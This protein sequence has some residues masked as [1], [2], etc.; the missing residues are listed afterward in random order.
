MTAVRTTASRRRRASPLGADFAGAGRRSLLRG[1]GPG[2]CGGTH[3]FRGPRDGTGGPFRGGKALAA[4][5]GARRHQRPSGPR[6]HRRDR[7]DHRG[8]RLPRPLLGPR[9]AL[10]L[11]HPRPPLAAGPGPGTGLA[12][13]KTAGRRS[14]AR[15]R[16]APDRPSRLHHLSRRPV[17]G[18]FAGQ[19]AGRGAGLARRRGDPAGVRLPLLP[20]SA[21][22]LDDRVAGGRGLRAAGPPTICRPRWKPPTAPAAARSPPRRGCI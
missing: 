19:D 17:P 15:R 13:E 7:G 8:R 9:A 1:S 18:Q 16:P 6:A 14:H 3:G 11:P 2:A 22:A 4:G 12:R 20:A 5:R 10:H 21:G